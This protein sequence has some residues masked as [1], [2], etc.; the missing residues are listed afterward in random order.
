MTAESITE[1]IAQHLEG[2]DIFLVEVAVRPGNAIRVHVDK[3]EGISID[4]CV[5]ISRFLN[6]RLDRDVE[7]YSLEVSSPGLSGTFK[8]KQQYEKNLGRNIEVLYSDGIKVKGKLE[9]VSDNGIT[10]KVNGD[11]EEIRFDEIKTAKAIISFN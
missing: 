11:D 8:V 10:L 9:S 2:S 5:K 7:D 6:E 4:E 1:L 3:P